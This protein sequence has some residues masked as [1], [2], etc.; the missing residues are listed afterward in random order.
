[1]KRD[2]LLAL[3]LLALFLLMIWALAGAQHWT[4]PAA[5]G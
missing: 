4:I 3:V 2:I 5:P 1:V